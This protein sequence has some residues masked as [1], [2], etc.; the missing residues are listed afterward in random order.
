MAAINWGSIEEEYKGGDFKDYAPEGKYTVK[1]VDVET[2]GTILLSSS[3]KIPTGISSRQ[4]TTGCRKT[5]PTGAS[6]I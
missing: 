3:S 6:S 1:L 4:P 2:K 5:K